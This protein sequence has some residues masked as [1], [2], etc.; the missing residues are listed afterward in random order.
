LLTPVRRPNNISDYPDVA[1]QQSHF[2]NPAAIKYL[3][4]LVSICSISYFRFLEYA[5]LACENCQT[6]AAPLQLGHRV[7]RIYN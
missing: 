7:V 2:T 5:N 4:L 1:R 3:Q 6:V